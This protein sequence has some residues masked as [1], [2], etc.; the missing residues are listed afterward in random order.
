MSFPVTLGSVGGTVGG[1]GGSGGAGSGGNVTF[2]SA[3]GPGASAG[4]NGDGAKG[5]PAVLKGA[6]ALGM[7]SLALNAPGETVLLGSEDM[8]AVHSTGSPH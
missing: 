3:A 5:D 2:P 1:T 4:L 8:D 7:L 6:S